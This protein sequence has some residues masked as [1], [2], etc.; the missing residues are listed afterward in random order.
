MR[1]LPRNCACCSSVPQ[2][3]LGDTTNFFCG[4]DVLEAVREWRVAH[5][6]AALSSSMCFPNDVAST[7]GM[8]CRREGGEVCQGEA[9]PCLIYTITAAFFEANIP[10]LVSNKVI[11]KKVE[12]LV[13]EDRKVE[14]GR[15]K[16]SA[17]EVARRAAHQ[18][19]LDKTF[20]ILREDARDLIN[21]CPVR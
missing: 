1:P 21:L 2:E 16:N 18:A 19:T 3:Q 11:K 17:A 10:F 8:R 12:A 14:R 13:E 6:R 15:L 7:G 5:P 4:R 9:N 20:S